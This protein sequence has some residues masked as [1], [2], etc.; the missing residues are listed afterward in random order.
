M[1]PTHRKSW[2]GNLM[3]LLDLTFGLSF[4]VKRRFTG[5]GELSFWWIQICIGSP[6]CRSSYT[7]L[8]LQFWIICA[9]DF[10]HIK[11]WI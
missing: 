4:K 3:I 10:K 8:I 2:A 7:Y 6:M 1:K 9:I 11:V 5:F